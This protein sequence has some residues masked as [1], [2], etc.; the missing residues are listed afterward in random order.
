MS[1]T[2]A[3]HS[4]RALGSIVSAVQG[5]VCKMYDRGS[6]P[7]A[8]IPVLQKLCYSTCWKIVTWYQKT[9]FCWCRRYLVDVSVG[10]SVQLDELDCFSSSRNIVATQVCS[11]LTN[12]FHLFRGLPLSRRPFNLYCR[13][14][15]CILFDLLLHP[16]SLSNFVC[17]LLSY[18]ILIVFL[19]IF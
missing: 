5:V 3:L 19:V 10:T 15:L 11:D 13:I 1:R 17:V 4:W 16:N 8:R 9:L 7:A 12:S 18:F 6:Q 14:C 2:D